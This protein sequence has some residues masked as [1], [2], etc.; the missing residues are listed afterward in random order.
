MK[1]REDALKVCDDPDRIDNSKRDDQANWVVCRKCKKCLNIRHTDIAGR[2]MAE[3]LVSD[4]TIA[5]TLTYADWTGARAQHLFYRDVQLML[6]RLRKDGYAVRFLAAGE[7][8]TKRQRAHWHVVLWFQGKAPAFPPVET[9]KQHWKYW[10]D[11][12]HNKAKNNGPVPIGFV[13]VQR[14]DF[15]GLR[16]VVKYA[17]KDEGTGRSTRKVQQSLKPP[18]GAAYWHRL[19][20]QEIAQGVPFRFSYALPDCRYGNGS[21]VQFYAQGASAVL[22]WLAYRDAWHKLNPNRVPPVHLDAYHTWW[23]MVV[24]PALRQYANQS[25]R[26]VVLPKGK[27][28]Y[29]KSKRFGKIALLLLRTG[30]WIAAKYL[31]PNNGLYLWRVESLSEMIAIARGRPNRPV[32][33]LKFGQIPF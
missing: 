31:G 21:P 13:F 26:D 29:V 12:P 22:K 10:A 1:T 4:H 23:R 15:H 24:P 18:L 7:Y 19:A 5:L 6:K 20:Q 8:G 9:E 25:R 3:T 28:T 33:R 17:C 30:D 27:A 32:T 14:P 16:Y 2:A 11:V